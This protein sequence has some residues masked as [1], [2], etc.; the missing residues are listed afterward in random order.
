LYNG[1]AW[2]VIG[3]TTG[4]SLNGQ[5][6]RM[7]DLSNTYFTLGTTTQQGL[8]LMTLEATSTASIPLTLVARDSQTAN[9]FQ[10]R[11]SGSSDLLYVDSGGGLFGSSTAQFT[12]AVTAY[13]DVTLGDAATDQLT[14][15]ANASTSAI[16][17]SD[18]LWVNGYATTTGSNGNI[19][20][21]G[22]LTVLGGTDYWNSNTLYSSSGIM[23]ANLLQVGS[24]T[25]GFAP[26]VVWANTPYGDPA[27][28]VS[29]NASTTLFTIIN[30]GNNNQGLV[31]INQA[32]PG[33]ALSVTGIVAINDDSSDAELSFQAGGTDMWRIRNDATGLSTDNAFVIWDESAS[34][35][36]LMID[37][38]GRIGIGTTTPTVELQIATTTA[39]ATTTVEIGKA[40][41]NKGSCLKLYN[42]VGTVYY[43]R[44]DGSTWTCDT[45]ACN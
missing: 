24:T 21:E 25:P 2:G 41:Q 29:N 10:I 33:S 35:E 32:N 19:A 39:N 27:M 4:L 18:S 28:Y 22:T 7:S 42:S 34:T 45:T 12:G 11:D 14:V 37:G 43:C 40:N 23:A 30:D 31:G 5:S 16:T 6:I 3:T 20:T 38:L 8:S 1:S 44:I 17:T 36:R 9:T 15:N 26:L 13:G